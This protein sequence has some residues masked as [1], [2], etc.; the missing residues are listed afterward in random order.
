MCYKVITHSLRCDVR[1]LISDGD[2]D[3]VSG[4]SDPVSCACTPNPA[5]VPWLQCPDHGCCRTISRLRRCTNINPCK[6]PRPFHLYEQA[7]TS[8]DPWPELPVLDKAFH[9][10]ATPPTWECP[11]WRSAL[12]EV[13]RAGEYIKV[14]QA[15]ML[16]SRNAIR[17]LE[18][19]HFEDH[20]MCDDCPRAKTIAKLRTV[21]YMNAREL[22]GLIGEFKAGAWLVGQGEIR[23]G[24]VVSG[25][26]APR[27]PGIP[28]P[29]D[30]LS[31]SNANAV[32][33]SS[34][35]GREGRTPLFGCEPFPGE[36][37]TMQ[38]GSGYLHL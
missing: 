17:V 30:L 18:R 16:A 32:F 33:L 8:T 24:R 13:V 35:R 26:S 37:L 14:G 2:R 28:T 34:G 20:G 27:L 38:Q 4:Y 3:I 31:P 7:H 25:L 23:G 1:P 22:P 36:A 11:A 5:I 9:T 10:R 19:A 21:E 29:R 15:L 6:N 12:M